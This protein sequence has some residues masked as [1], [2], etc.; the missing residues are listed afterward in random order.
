MKNIFILSFILMLIFVNPCVAEI[1]TT[2]NLYFDGNGLCEYPNSGWVFLEAYDLD[3]TSTTYAYQS[4]LYDGASTQCINISAS[5]TGYHNY[6]NAPVSVSRE[7]SYKW[8]YAAG[9]YTLRNVFQTNYSDRACI[10]ATNDDITMVCKANI[11]TGSG[12]SGECFAAFSAYITPNDMEEY[13]VTGDTGCV[14]NVS[15][16]AFVNDTY[17]LLSEDDLSGDNAYRLPII[18]GQ[19]YRLLFFD[20][21]S[22][23]FTC[24]GDV[25]Y[26][27]TACAYTRIYLKDYCGNMMQNTSCDIYKSDGGAPATYEFVGNYWNTNP[28]ELLV[29]DIGEGK[30]LDIYFDTDMGSY[31]QIE[32][33]GDKNVDV[34]HPLKWWSISFGAFDDITHD[35]IQNIKMVVN[36]TCKI[37]PDRELITNGFTDATGYKMFTCLSG[38]NVNIRMGND[39]YGG[40]RFFVGGLGDA[41]QTHY[42]IDT[43]LNLSDEIPMD[44]WNNTNLSVGCNIHFKDISGHVDNHINDT[45]TYVDLYYDN[46]N[47]TATLKFQR[48]YST[49]W[50]TKE[51]YNIPINES[52]YKR[53]LNSNFSEHDA[54]YRAIM[55]AIECECNVTLSLYVTNE[56]VQE[57]EHY[58]NLT[59]YIRFNHQLGGGQVDYRSPISIKAYAY[60]NYSAYLLNINLT[61]YEQTNQIAT[62]QC[63][64]ADFA[65][66][67][68][69]WFYTWSPNVDYDVGKNYTVV[70]TGYNGL[71][72]SADDVWTSNIR[73]NKLTVNVQDNHGAPL[74][75]STVF[76]QDWGS[77]A[78]DSATSTTIEGF[79]DDSHQYKATKSGYLSSGWYTVIFNDSDESV[80]C[81]L[82]ETSEES[83]TG[84]KLK[85]E[86]I[87]SFFIPLMYMLLIMI[88][89]GGLLNAAKP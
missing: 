38:Q 70:M 26:D 79:E 69:K 45:D 86:E 28:V 85:D 24:S 71:N 72:L 74:A 46:G 88:L 1:W 82:T 11:Q 48:L 33:C 51:S 47:C 55:T 32:F 9:S 35:P 22:Y 37:C 44:D 59:T 68:P 3:T 75:Y 62:K 23:D 56:T 87:K 78:L 76:V 20:G 73:N 17:F 54:C 34:L 14:N 81:T 6:F 63:D 40:D 31:H 42:M 7:T 61:L 64:W 50:M 30:M 58:E 49:Y 12:G 77:I 66:A 2:E 52:G 57:E 39:L 43:Y 80:T 83:V 5:G 19:S 4:T 16:Y 25:V 65:G 89:I 21:E 36:Q 60:T 84:Y 29:S 10:A 27:Y 18:S 41:F 67:T 13:N 53:I 15:L 8:Y